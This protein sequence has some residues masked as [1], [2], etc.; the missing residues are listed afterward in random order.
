MKAGTPS[1]QVPVPVLASGWGRDP[2]AELQPRQNWI[3][4]VVVKVSGLSRRSGVCAPS[5]RLSGVFST[6]LSSD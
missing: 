1:G 4:K 2:G 5:P 6:R 3:W